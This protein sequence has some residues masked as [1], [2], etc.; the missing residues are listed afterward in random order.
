[1]AAGVRSSGS[2]DIPPVTRISSAPS[3]R[4]AWMAATIWVVSSG[5]RIC[6]VTWLPSAATLARITGPNLSS[7]RPRNT[8]LPVVTTPTRRLRSG[9]TSMTGA[10]PPHSDS[11]RRDVDD[12]RDD[13]AAGHGLPLLHQLVPVDRRDADLVDPI[14][15]VER[16]DVDLEQAPRPRLQLD[17]ALDGLGELEPSPRHR[18]RDPRR[19]VVLVQRPRADLPRVQVLLPEVEEPGD[20]LLADDVPLLE[21]PALEPAWDDLGDVVAEHGAFR[22]VNRDDLHRPHPFPA[23]AHLAGGRVSDRAGDSGTRFASP[24]LLSNTRARG[25]PEEATRVVAGFGP[26]FGDRPRSGPHRPPLCG[27]ATCHVRFTAAARGD[28][29]FRLFPGR[30]TGMRRAPSLSAV[31]LAVRAGSPQASP[32]PPRSR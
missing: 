1:M 29:K 8:S 16:V 20:V 26:G 7:I 6:R 12:Q 17:L 10:A 25:R 18:A 31:L 4:R 3:A 19:G 15:R 22:L 32:P 11:A 13:A 14:D 9:A 30:I 23:T 27:G 5:T 24:P 28:P 2:T 21:R